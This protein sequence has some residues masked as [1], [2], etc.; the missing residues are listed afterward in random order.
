MHDRW[1]RIASNSFSL[2]PFLPQTQVILFLLFAA[3]LRAYHS[4][5]KSLPLRVIV[6]RDGVGDGQVSDCSI[7][8]VQ[9]ECSAAII[10][11]LLFYSC[12][13]LLNMSC[14][15]SKLLS[16]PYQTTSNQSIHQKNTYMCFLLMPLT[17]TPPLSPPPCFL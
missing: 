7:L 11:N 1:V 6:Y 10:L 8:L 17:N 13:S 15:R 4:A 3:A 2:S 12:Q 9:T 14:H 5:N 16:L